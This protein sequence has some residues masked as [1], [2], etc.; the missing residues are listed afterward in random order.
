MSDWGYADTVASGRRARLLN[1]PSFDVIS[2]E[3]VEHMSIG[4]CHD[5]RCCDDNRFSRV[6]FCIRITCP[7]FDKFFN[8][9][10]G[11]RGAYYQSPY[12]GSQA[13]DEFIRR[14]SPILLKW[15]ESNCDR[16]R[17]E[18]A[19]ESLSSPSAKVWL[20]EVNK[21]L[22]SECE[23]E[24]SVPQDDKAEIQNERWEKEET[25]KAKWGR[26]APTGTKLRIFGAFLD[27]K[28]NVFIAENK[29]YR[30]VEIHEHGW[31]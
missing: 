23:G 22:C 13:N 31:S 18:F 27:E 1:A 3:V 2:Q 21:N 6:V 19:K 12:C 28:R 20:A 17:S 10:H 29:R 11:Y 4:C 9:L 24:W 15:A 8:S 5:D 7:L 14:L 25:Q 16:F 30:A 26:K